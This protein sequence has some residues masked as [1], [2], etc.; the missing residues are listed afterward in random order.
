MFFF[1]SLSA[2]DFLS[3]LQ[4]RKC[5][6]LLTELTDRK[7]LSGTHRIEAD[8]QYGMKLRLWSVLSHSNAQNSAFIIH[9]DKKG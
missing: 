2:S 6:C 5:P 9:Y 8:S 4:M 7:S 3:H 1:F